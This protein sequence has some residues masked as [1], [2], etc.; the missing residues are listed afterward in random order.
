MGRGRAR[1][2]VWEIESEGGDGF[3]SFLQLKDCSKW[4]ADTN[5]CREIIAQRG[6]L[7]ACLVLAVQ[8]S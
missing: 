4:P 8:S 7:S 2:T 5:L 3:L 6:C 1:E